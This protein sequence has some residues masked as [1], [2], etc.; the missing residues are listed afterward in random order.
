MLACA[1]FPVGIPGLA[2]LLRLDIIFARQ[3]PDADS[4]QHDGNGGH[5]ETRGWSLGQVLFHDVK[6]LEADFIMQRQAINCHRVS[7]MSLTK[8]SS[9]DFRPFRLNRLVLIDSINHFQDLSSHVFGNG[10]ANR[11]LSK[12][13]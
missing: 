7:V 3:R 9:P 2:T 10:L 8:I 11:H 13:R 5:G 12:P 1:S 6:A 4:E